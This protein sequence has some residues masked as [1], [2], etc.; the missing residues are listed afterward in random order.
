[1]IMKGKIM[2][3][4]RMAMQKTDA[5][6]EDELKKEFEDYPIDVNPYAKPVKDEKLK[7][8]VVRDILTQSKAM[9]ETTL[10]DLEDEMKEAKEKEERIKASIVDARAALN[11]VDD[12]LD[13]GKRF[14]K[15]RT[16]ADLHI[17]SEQRALQKALEKKDDT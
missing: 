17:A 1:M 14:A 6:F 16:K 7:V 10:K 3:R 15:E 5:A 13:A 8:D 9:L 2:N 4:M 12:G 11:M